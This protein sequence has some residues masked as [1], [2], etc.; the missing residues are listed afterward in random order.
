MK[1]L[2]RRFAP[3]LLAVTALIALWMLFFW[4]IFT[5]INADQA[6]LEKGDFSGQFVA[7]AAYQY[8]RWSAGE[9]PLWNPYNNGG[10]P[11][12]ADTQAAVF[13]PPRLVTIAL[14]HVSGGWSYRALEYEMTAHVL[15]YTLFM[16]AFM[17]RLTYGRRGSIIGAFVGALIVGYSGFS[18]GY[19]PLQL[20]ILEAAIWLPLALLGIHEASRERWRPQWLIITG[21][22]LGLSWLAGHPQTSFFMTYLLTAYL[23]IQVYRRR[24]RWHTFVIGTAFFGAIAFGCAAVQLIPG[25]EYL[26]LTTRTEFGYD[27]KGNGF[28]FQDIIQFVFPGIVSL[29]SPLYIGFTGLVLAL[30]AVYRREK[31]AVFWGV[32]A[33]FALVWSFCANSALF[34]A[35]YNLVPGLRFFRG[36]ERAAFLV[37]QALAILAGL[38]AAHLLDWDAVRDYA[39]ALRI[40]IWLNRIFIGAMLVGALMFVVW[41]DGSGGF[42]ERISLFAF[43]LIMIGAV[44]LLIPNLLAYRPRDLAF[45]SIAGLLAFELFTV[46]MDS[47]A[48]YDA[49]PPEDQLSIAPPP[50]IADVLSDSEIPFRVDGERGVLANYGS[51]YGVQD[52]RGISPL[53]LNRA[54]TILSDDSL[55]TRAWELFAVRYVFTDWN[56]LPIASEIVDAG[57]DVFGAINLHRLND[58]RPFA[59]VIH[60]HYI[61]PSDEIAINLLRDPGID[62]RRIVILNRDPGVPSTESEQPSVPSQVT[63]FSPERVTITVLADRPGILSAAI[64]D[65]PGWRATVNGESVEIIRAYG[66]LSAVPVGEGE[67]TVEFIYDPLTYRLGAMISAVTWVALGVIGLILGIYAAGKRTSTLGRRA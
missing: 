9:V 41:I 67:S 57:S 54:W 52:I 59:L 2:N 29:Y 40:R 4:R 43:A 22:A 3:D 27:A 24:L 10:L 36:Q 7:F 33:L 11:F 14:A 56:Q 19:A 46:N 28:P 66:A 8:D 49:V 1:P 48:T 34:P 13:Y 5:P 58:P 55:T 42:A 44:Y 64:V 12:I 51:L 25:V 23:G 15:V 61:E 65:Y 62:P 53:F 6:S 60:Q 45:W 63:F 20:A 18:T 32:V 47:P 37:M 50:L 26:T 21:A 39:V 38:G 31:E 35:L 16:Y 30:I 17:R